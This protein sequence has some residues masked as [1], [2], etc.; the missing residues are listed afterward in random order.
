MEEGTGVERFVVHDVLEAYQS[1]CELELAPAE[2]VRGRGRLRTTVVLM[3][4]GFLYNSRRP[5]PVFLSLGSRL[6]KP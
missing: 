6:S 3:E 2:V 1:M 4:I 5:K